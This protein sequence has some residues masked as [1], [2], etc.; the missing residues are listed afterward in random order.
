M[1]SYLFFIISWVVATPFNILTHELGHAIPALLFTQGPVYLDLCEGR[2]KGVLKFRIGR[3]H[4]SLSWKNLF[5]ESGLTEHILTRSDNA[6]RLVILSGVIFSGFVVGGI[7]SIALAI[8]C[9]DLVAIAIY[10]AL[11]LNW[12]FTSI[13]S[14][15]PREQNIRGKIHESDGLRFFRTF[16]KKGLAELHF[17]RHYHYEEYD[18]ALGA[19]KELPIDY[20]KERRLSTMAMFVCLKTKAFDILPLYEEALVKSND[21]L[22]ILEVV[23]LLCVEI[24][25]YDMAERYLLKWEDLEPS[26]ERILLQ[27]GILRLTQGDYPA[28]KAQF[29][30]ALKNAA[31]A[32]TYAWLA[33]ID[34]KLRNVESCYEFL[35]KALELDPND[36]VVVQIKEAID[37][38]SEVK[39]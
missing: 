38:D 30:E 1:N 25:A 33:Y 32:S 13:V 11:P 2:V 35:N 24:E 22:Q 31:S 6:E 39:D 17:L 36:K 18:Q 20:I 21:L 3:L 14:L 5:F 34:C 8:P 28:A 15:F 9:S 10:I 37:E 29:S 4:I 16:Q 23:V 26:N 7:I 19:L 12:L 27:R